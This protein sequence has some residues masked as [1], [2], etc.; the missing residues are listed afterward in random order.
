MDGWTTREDKKLGLGKI[1]LEAMV[2]HPVCKICR[3]PSGDND[4]IRRETQVS[5]WMSLG[6][7]GRRS[8][9]NLT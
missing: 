7:S 4:V 1:K 3:D 8:H 6:S 9:D 2:P 5:I